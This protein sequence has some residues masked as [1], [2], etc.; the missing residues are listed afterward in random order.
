MAKRKPAEVHGVLCLDKPLGMTSRTALNRASRLLHEKRAGH[1][2]TLDPDASGVLL[3]CFGEATKAVRWLM[4]APKSY[5]TTVRFGTATLS[6]DA[7]SPVV[8]T[9]D[10]PVLTLETVTAA[11]PH[12]GWIQQVPPAVSALQQDGV[13][14]H[15]RV[16]RG[17]IVE[18]EARPVQLHAV[19]VLGIQ[20]ADV[21][22]RVTCGSGFYVR[23]LARDLGEALGSA[24][25]VIELRRTAGASFEVRDAWTLEELEGMEEEQRLATL[26]PVEVALGRVLPMLQVDAATEVMLRQGKLPALASD[27]KGMQARSVDAQHRVRVADPQPDPAESRIRPEDAANDPET[28]AEQSYLIL[29]P[30]AKAVCVAEIVAQTRESPAL[31]RVVRGFCA[32]VSRSAMPG[33]SDDN[34]S[35]NT[36]I[37]A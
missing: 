19:E 13:R 33:E 36:E 10:V 4:D 22:L 18:R 26:V 2:G 34:G 15:E 29:G 23:A 32:T 37:G 14:D 25:H 11:L 30:S 24:A 5:E 3:L 16:R 8:R 1:A 20:D 6:D 17:E 9:A 7:A 21:R 27:A 12:P 31:L 28:F 35:G